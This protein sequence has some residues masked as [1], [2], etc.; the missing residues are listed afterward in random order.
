ML[1]LNTYRFR[2]RV[3]WL[4][5]IIRLSRLSKQGLRSRYRM[6]SNNRINRKQAIKLLFI[7]LLLLSKLRLYYYFSRLSKL[8]TL[9]WLSR[10]NN[11]FTRLNSLTSLIWLRWFL[12]GRGYRQIGSWQRIR[13]SNAR[14]H[15]NLPP[16]WRRRWLFRSTLLHST[17]FH[18]LIQNLF[19]FILFL[20][21]NINLVVNHINIEI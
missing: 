21:G 16:F 19:T 6:L 10:Y 14:F 7:L 5:N 17:S 4:R 18:P 20:P 11:W 15:V 1:L 2:L 13:L 8:S 12:G 9:T 3:Y